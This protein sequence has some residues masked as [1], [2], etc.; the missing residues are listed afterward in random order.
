MAARLEQAEKARLEKQARQVC[1]PL[2]NSLRICVLTL[3]PRSPQA[4]KPKK[5]PKDET[6]EEA[7]RFASSSSVASETHQLTCISVST[8]KGGKSRGWFACPS[9]TRS[10]HP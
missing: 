4:A 10:S 7:V 3:G 1:L 2:V 5:E 8:A 9:L 6:R